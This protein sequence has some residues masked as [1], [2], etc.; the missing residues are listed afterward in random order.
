[1]LAAPGH[2]VVQDD[3][4]CLRLGGL[5]CLLEQRLLLQ[6]LL[7]AMGEGQVS[8]SP[9]GPLSVI[10]DRKKIWNG[11]Y[12]QKIRRYLCLFLLHA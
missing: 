3:D 11:R 10:S 6:Y 2:L 1:M 4:V 8:I 5:Q 12:K 9:A 7:F